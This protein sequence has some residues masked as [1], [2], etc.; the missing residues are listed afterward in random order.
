MKIF[1]G[2]KFVYALLIAA[3]AL[4]AFGVPSVKAAEGTGTIV[5]VALA[6]NAETGE[7]SILIAALQAAN[8]S[9]IN[10]LSSERQ[11]TVFAPTDAAFQA[12][13]AELGVSAEQLLSDRNLV[14][15]V[16]R[17]HVVRGNLD[18][19]DVLARERLRTLRGGRLL[20][21]NG[22]LTDPNGRTAKIVQTDIQASNG[23]IHVIDRVILPK[24]DQAPEPDNTIVD[25]ALA[26]N[27]ETGE[28]SILIAALE[29][30]NPSVIKRL[31]S[32]RQSTIFAPTDAAFEALLA[33]LGVTAE[34][35]L[36]DQ[37]LVTKVLRYHIVRGN[38][39][40]T[41][42]LARERLRTLQGSRLSQENGVLTDF[43][44]RTANI[45]QTDIQASNGV[46]HVIDQVVLPNLTPDSDDDNDN[47]DDEDEDDDNDDDD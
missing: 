44:G 42:V 1:S 9:V 16:L 15:R 33:E 2:V 22:V 35:L 13:L 12:L 29:A 20:Q 7:F 28:F 25:V 26:A 21:S 4:G 37:A 5:D 10:R 47:D 3:L 17:Y 36:S 45:I 19:T 27:E 34:Q 46:I 30:A 32:E 43:N 11:S 6:A 41:E 18:S 39:D 8:P 40:S 23:V 38:L 31:S 24:I 14:T